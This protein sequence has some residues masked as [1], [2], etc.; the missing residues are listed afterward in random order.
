[1]CKCLVEETGE[2][3]LKNKPL[4]EEK[5]GYIEQRLQGQLDYYHRKCLSL[6]KEYYC[7]STLN[8]I[9][10]AL[11]PTFTL[12]V[13]DYTF[14]KYIIAALGAAA[15]ILTSILLL[16]KTKETHLSF[17][18][19]YEALK[20]ERVFYLNRVG[21]YAEKEP[22]KRSILF[23]TNCEKLMMDEQKAWIV[24]QQDKN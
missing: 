12:A 21:D 16:H 13:D 20:R 11:I 4:P 1:M 18:S 5:E 24:Q 14:F 10:T 2:T 3:R 6:K 22:E 19:T 17:R 15:S 7:L 23:I 9:A 8:I